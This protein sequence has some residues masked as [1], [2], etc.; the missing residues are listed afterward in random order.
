M[1]GENNCITDGESLMIK[2]QSIESERNIESKEKKT[3]RHGEREK[4]NKEREWNTR[5]KI[6][7]KKDRTIK[8]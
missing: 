4:I 3:Q 5:W 2:K 6:K 8:W 1:K 7:I